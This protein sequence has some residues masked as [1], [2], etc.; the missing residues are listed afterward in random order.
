MAAP[1]PNT[2]AVAH[3]AVGLAG[4]LAAKKIFGTG[5]VIVFL[6][7]LAFVILFHEALDAPVAKVMA[8]I[9]FQF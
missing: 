6:A 9:G 2:R 8:G 7:G 3:A 1:T 4:G 5:G